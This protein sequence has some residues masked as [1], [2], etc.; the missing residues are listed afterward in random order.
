MRARGDRPTS[1]SRRDIAIRWPGRPV[2]PDG[3][4]HDD[5][6]HGD[7][8]TNT[9][10]ADDRA[11][12]VIADDRAGP[13]IADDSATP[14]IAHRAGP[15]I[16]D[17]SFVEGQAHAHH[18]R[19]GDEVDRAPRERGVHKHPECGLLG[20]H[21][22]TRVDRDEELGGELEG[23]DEDLAPVDRPGSG[24]GTTGMA[25]WTRRRTMSCAFAAGSVRAK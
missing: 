12:P 17:R 8:F 19:L 25:T 4:R 7:V 21:G 1:G 3:D 9:V 5:R 14:A 10:I 13:V 20:R 18:A 23:L 22:I 2:L 16:A 11:T 24:G 15:M 6:I